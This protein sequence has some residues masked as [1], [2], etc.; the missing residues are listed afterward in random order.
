MTFAAIDC[1]TNSTRLLVHDGS[2]TVERLTT[3][4][5]LGQGVD[6]TGRFH[7]D[8]I[9]RTLDVLRRYRDVMDRHGVRA[10]RVAATS[11]AR[12]AAN[13]DE[14]FDAAEA[15]VGARPELLAG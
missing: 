12:D 10:V 3:I 13:R 6:A 7:P 14:L 2:R 5:R 1:G 8:A 11:A 9:A 4:T 15:V